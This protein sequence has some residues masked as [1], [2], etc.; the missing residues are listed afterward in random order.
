MKALIY[1]GKV[2]QL[3]EEA[4]PVAAGL[5]WVETSE[6]NEVKCGD[7][8]SGSVFTT[9]EPKPPEPEPTNYVTQ[10]L[11]A[12]ASFCLGKIDKS[13]LDTAFKNYMAVTGKVAK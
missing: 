8:Y 10:L 11:E 9:P 12:V 7:V 3:E 2:I 4:F 13:A 5:S 1:Q 6:E